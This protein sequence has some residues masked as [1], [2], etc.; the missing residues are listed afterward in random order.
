[1]RRLVDPLRTLREVFANPA[2]RRIQLAWAG[3]SIAAWSYGIALVV[4]AFE[5][6]GA[7]GVGLIGLIRWLL[8]AGIAPVSGVL[9]DRYPRAAVMI[10]ANLTRTAAMAGMGIGAAASAPSAVVYVLAVVVTIASTAFRPAQ[11]SLLPSLARTP[12][13]LAAANVSSSTIESVGIF[14]GPA[15]GG[16]LLAGTSVGVV[17]FATAALYVVSAALLVPL[18]RRREKEREVRSRGG[19]G[20]EMLAGINAIASEPRLRLL[21]GLYAAQT[22]VDGALGVLIAVLALDLLD[23]GGGTV[24]FMNSALGIGGVLGAVAATALGARGRLAG[25]FGLGIVLWGIPIVAIGVWPN[26]ATALILLGVVGLGNTVVDVSS[27]TLLQRSVPSD[28][29]GRVFAVFRSLMFATTALGAITTPLLVSAFGGRAAL[30]CVGAV[31]PVLAV[32]SWRRLAEI[33][34][35]ARVPARG[36]ELLQAIPI[37]APLPLP[38]L[39]RLAMQ[40]ERE[41]ARDGETIVRHG[42]RGDRFYVVAAG[43]VEVDVGGR[44]RPP[45]EA[46]GFFGEIALLRDEPRTA[47]VTAAPDVELFTLARDDFLA[48]VAGHPDSTAAAAAVVR[49]RL[50]A[51]RAGVALT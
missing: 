31:L 35:E 24:G 33:D 22:F 3:A 40:L 38:T 47:T 44:P 13:E 14:A 9:A 1:M 28:V 51:P 36:I 10:G 42:E 34:A 15:L 37:F 16:L 27:D 17:F 39:T 4:Y 45:I 29:L 12:Q 7:Y 8:A 18:V 32:L 2:L 50:E 11:S 48:A 23:L 49:A 46:G 21:I 43:R 20:A 41:T 19:V 6:D 26:A 30:I 25:D 5:Q